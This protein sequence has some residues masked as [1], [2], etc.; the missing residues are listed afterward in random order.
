MCDVLLNNEEE[1]QYDMGYSI[2]KSK[3]PC[4]MCVFIINYNVSL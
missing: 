4:D 3:V 2:M 1:V